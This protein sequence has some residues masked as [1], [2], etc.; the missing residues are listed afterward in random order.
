MSQLLETLATELER[1]RELSARV[2]N[3]VGGTYGI[4]HDTIG[5][6]LVEELPRL[7]DYEIDL[8]LAD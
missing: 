2:V 5:V 7:E 3:Y 4:D 8:V 6:F 1:P